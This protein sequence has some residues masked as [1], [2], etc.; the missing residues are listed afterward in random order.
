MSF[1]RISVPR[2]L[3]API[4]GSRR[5]PPI[6]IVLDWFEELKELAP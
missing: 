2:R 4:E 1:A 6:H 3:E 5:A